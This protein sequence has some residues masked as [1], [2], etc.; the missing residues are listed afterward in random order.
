MVSKDEMSKFKKD[1]A[2]MKQKLQNLSTQLKESENRLGI[3]NYEKSSIIKENKELKNILQEKLSEVKRLETRLLQYADKCTDIQAQKRHMAK[4]QS[5]NDDLNQK[6]KNLQTVEKNV[7]K[8]KKE[9]Q[10]LETEMISQR[11]NIVTLNS[12]VKIVNDCK[13]ELEE[14]LR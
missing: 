8:L 13:L 4:L 1:N 7:Q 5:E 10:Q 6:C 2:E 3:N 9:K 12:R 14:R 11:Q